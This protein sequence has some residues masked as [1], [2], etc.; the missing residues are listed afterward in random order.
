MTDQFTRLARDRLQQLAYSLT[1]LRE[2]VRDAVA[3]E[4]GKAVGDA[5]RDLLTA[6]LSKTANARRVAEQ[7]QT[8]PRPSEPAGWDD[9]DEPDWYDEPANTTRSAWCASPPPIQPPSTA[10]AVGLGVTITRWLLKRQIPIWAGLGAGL[11]AGLATLSPHPFVQAGLG[12][13]AAAAE[14]LAITEFTSNAL[15]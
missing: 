7:Q 4:M 3:S 6:V 5:L 9:D 12:V 11:L 2:R 15:D 8:P 14:L 13:V 1:T 10:A